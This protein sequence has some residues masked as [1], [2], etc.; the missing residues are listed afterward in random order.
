MPLTSHSSGATELGFFVSLT[1]WLGVF[2]G[3]WV[4]ERVW[5]GIVILCIFAV[6]SLKLNSCC[7]IA[8]S[9][10]LMQDIDSVQTVYQRNLN[11]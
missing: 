6:L 5:Y 8:K 10:M 2:D 7:V 11:G 1:E 3:S 4:F 9:K